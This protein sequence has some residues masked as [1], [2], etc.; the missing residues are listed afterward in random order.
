[1]ITPSDQKPQERINEVYFEQQPDITPP[2]RI[3]PDLMPR[4][5][6][7]ASLKLMVPYIWK[8]MLIP[9]KEQPQSAASQPT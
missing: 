9:G 7:E 6:I 8:G 5:C 4:T 3:R 1:M 2:H